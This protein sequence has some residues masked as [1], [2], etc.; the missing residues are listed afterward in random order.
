MGSEKKRSI[1][2][3]VRSLHRYIGYFII[4]F[5]VIYSLSGIVLIYRDTDFLKHETL[6]EKTVAPN[7]KADELGMALHFRGLKV[8]KEEGET[9]HFNNGTYHK[10]TGV[11][12]YTSKSLPLVLEKLSKLHKSSSKDSM[13]WFSMIFGILLFFLAISSFWMFESGTKHFRRNVYITIAGVL[14]ATIVLLL[15]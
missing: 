13:H 7:L 4:G 9:I 5:A 12:V 8:T 15:C 2:R 3:T 6:T 10:P 14:S 1:R 11:A